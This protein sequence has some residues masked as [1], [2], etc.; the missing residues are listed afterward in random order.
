MSFLDH[1]RMHGLIVDHVI[2]DGRWH[3]VK[4]V[5]HPRKRNGAY[6]FDGHRGACQ[7]WATMQSPATYRNGKDSEPDLAA[8]RRQHQQEKKD[9]TEQ[10]LQAG[11]QAAR[12]IG[13]A[14]LSTHP[15]L[16]AKGFPGELGFVLD[17]ELLIPMRDHRRYEQ[18]VGCQRI[19][20]EGGKK[21]VSGQRAKGA[22]YRL[23]PLRGERWLCEGYATG[24]SLHAALA[25]L[26]RHA[27][28]IVCFSAGNLIHVAQFVWLPTFVMA[29]N[30]ESRAGEE[31]AIK[32]GLPW[33]MP[34]TLGEDAND[35]QQRHGLRA[36]VK[37]I[38][39]VG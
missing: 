12:M 11:L 9:R 2:A 27:Q 23:G 17:G 14:A 32:T 19:T 5:D 3:R 18:L 15:Y 26:R 25:D 37:T 10:Y 21:F 16:A 1:A 6:A 35:M 22:V 34:P 31:A 20:A 24:L 8:L 38:L 7:N 33:V 13:S 30:D 29:D 36:L 39:G 4:T 28:V